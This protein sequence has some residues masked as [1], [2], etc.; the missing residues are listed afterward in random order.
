SGS[1]ITAEIFPVCD[2]YTLQG[3][4]FSRAILDGTEVPVPLEDAIRNMAV[5]DALFRSG[6]SGT[7]ETPRSN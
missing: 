2:Q 1:G 3:D 6:E 5:I 4:A 7:W